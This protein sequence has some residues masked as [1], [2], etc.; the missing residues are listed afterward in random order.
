MGKRFPQGVVPE[1]HVNKEEPFSAP[2][3]EI[4]DIESRSAGPAERIN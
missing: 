1:K 2:R 4:S 3:V